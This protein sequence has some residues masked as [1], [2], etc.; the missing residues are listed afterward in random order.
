MQ[1]TVSIPGSTDHTPVLVEAYVRDGAASFTAHDWPTGR[2]AQLRD[3]VRLLINTYGYRWP[4][5]RIAV[6]VTRN[7]PVDRQQIV[8][9]VAVAM[10]RADGQIAA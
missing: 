10:L 1:A 6:A 7:G 3:A 9:A 5:R 8:F 4:E 2:T